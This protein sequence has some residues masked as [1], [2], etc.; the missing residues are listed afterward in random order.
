MKDRRKYKKRREEVRNGKRTCNL[1][2]LITKKNVIY[3]AIFEIGLGM[4]FA[5]GKNTTVFDNSVL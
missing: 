3:S 4:S 2:K 1:L 5:I